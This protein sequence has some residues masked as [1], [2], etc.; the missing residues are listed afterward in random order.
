MVG[1]LEIKT[2][3]DNPEE[4]A[5]EWRR[6]G[7]CAIGFVGLGD[8]RARS[9][10]ELE[11]RAPEGYTQLDID[12]VWSFCR[13]LKNGDLILAYTKHNTIAYVGEVDGPYEFREDN[14]VG[15]PKG[16]GY[17]RQRQVEWWAEPHH[18]DRRNLPPYFA[19]QFGKRRFAIRPIDPGPYGF[20][21]FVKILKSC[22]ISGS[23]I[24]GM[25]EDMVKA[26]LV[27][28]LYRSLD[29]LEPG[30]RIKHV[31]PSIQRRKRPDF[32]AADK[33]GRPVLIECKGT[34][35]GDAVDQIKQYEKLYGMKKSSRLMIVAFKIDEMCMSAAKR[36]GNVELFECNLDFRKIERAP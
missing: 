2:H 35:S 24:P 22:P 26:G 28:Y 5:E 13:E 14:V 18:F 33:K 7:V 34:A 9:K 1:I 6:L 27:K 30:L 29:A 16:F 12:Q 19:K 11:K 25:N 3:H 32:I 4:A 36:A 17:P 20:D 15:N 23:R 21:G 31:E 10:R 8:F